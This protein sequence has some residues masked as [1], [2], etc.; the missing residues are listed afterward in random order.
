M[1][2]KHIA[3]LTRLVLALSLFV[4]VTPLGAFARQSSAKAHKAKLKGKAAHSAKSVKHSGAK[5]LSSAQPL[6]N[7]DKVLIAVGKAS[8]YANSFHGSKTA[9]GEQFDKKDFTAAHRSLPFGT[10]VRVTNLNNGKMV[11]VKINDR[12]PYIKSRI[13]DLS[14][15][16][17]KQLDLVDGGVGKVRI[18]AYN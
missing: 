18:E 12:G 17:A 3:Q 11:F 1:Q 6:P 15:A 10:V 8:F 9:S 4:S 13:I 2:K 16:A 7:G 14:K 5:E